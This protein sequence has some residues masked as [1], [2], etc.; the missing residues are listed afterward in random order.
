MAHNSERNGEYS[1]EYNGEHNGDYISEYIVVHHPGSVSE[2]RFFADLGHILYDGAYADRGTRPGG[3]HTLQRGGLAADEYWLTQLVAGSRAPVMLVSFFAGEMC[4]IRGL[5]PGPHSTPWALRL[6]AASVPSRYP[7]PK[8]RDL[9]PAPLPPLWM[10]SDELLSGP[11]AVEAIAGWS[12]ATDGA[13]DRAALAA[14]L[15]EEPEHFAEDL[16]DRLL[17]TLGLSEQVERWYPHLFHGWDDPVKLQRSIAAL[18]PGR[19]RA[20]D[21]RE[22][23]DCFALVRMRAEGDYT[24]EFRE[25]KSGTPQQTTTASLDAVVE[26]MNA[27]ARGEVAWRADFRWEEVAEVPSAGEAT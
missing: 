24:I 27:W 12:A 6:H 18:Q 11:A 25:Q 19:F 20:L 5:E 23:Q 10:I 16:L 13:P 9:Y 4:A 8:H 2:L 17:D 1:G 3:W 7:T 14:L 26:A 21:C 15:A 22:H